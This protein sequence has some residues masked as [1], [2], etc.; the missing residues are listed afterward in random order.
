[1]IKK[2]VH[3]L[4]FAKSHYLFTLLH[5]S[6]FHFRTLTQNPVYSSIDYILLVWVGH[7]YK[8]ENIFGANYL[9]QQ[10]IQLQRKQRE[11]SLWYWYRGSNLISWAEVGLRT[12]SCNLRRFTISHRFYT[13][14]FQ[15]QFWENLQPNATWPSAIDQVSLFNSTLFRYSI[16]PTCSAS[17]SSSHFQVST[18]SSQAIIIP[19][20]YLWEIKWILPEQ[21][22]KTWLFPFWIAQ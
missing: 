6:A 19:S 16:N 5:G 1:M 9:A 3:E 7:Y 18:V 13:L 15:T 17:E 22:Y 21:K 11:L 12:I 8:Q 10:W 20:K 4:F 14:K 2:R